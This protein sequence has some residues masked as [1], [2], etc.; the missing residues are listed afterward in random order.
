VDGVATEAAPRFWRD[1]L[2]LDG[3]ALVAGVAN[4]L[5]HV[6]VARMLGP[7]QYGILAALG[8]IV[9]LLELPV[10]MIALVYTRRG[11]APDR[12]TRLNGI[13]VGWGLLVWAGVWVAAPWLSRLFGLPARLVWLF[14]LAVVP[15]YAYGLNLGVM[16]WAA[17]FF[18]AGALVAWDAVARALA[19]L[20]ALVGQMGLMGLVVAAPLVTLSD[21][22]L[23][24]M[25][26]RGSVRRAR[27]EG[28]A[29]FGGLP[30]AAVV[31]ALTLVMT[32]ADVLAAKH[33]L[34]PRAAGFYGGL[35]TLGRAPV[36]FAGAVGTVL[37]SSAQ[38]QPS[39]GWRYLQYSLAVMAALDA[40]GAGLYALFGRFLITAALGVRF[41]PMARWL[42]PYTLGMG[43]EGLLL[44]TLYYGAARGRWTVTAVGGA[45]FGVWMAVLWTTHT[46]G[47]VVNETVAVMLAGF[48]A[49]A[50]GALWIQVRGRP[51]AT[52]KKGQPAAAGW[53]RAGQ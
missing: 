25:G 51:P 45:A 37:L 13:W 35:A 10:S 39:D 49:A 30:N 28:L 9:L 2:L 38:R 27:R 31:G 1:N 21:G 12:L 48:I 50:A 20:V 41:L 24:W 8:T 14:G 29:S 33:A 36:Y 42:V 3:G 6:T 44:V 17:Q 7:L 46:L 11:A 4:A 47:A 23:S 32:S 52:K 26:A 53:P 15:T 18:W 19:A 16:Q 22:L 43:L 40:L 5:Y 34:P